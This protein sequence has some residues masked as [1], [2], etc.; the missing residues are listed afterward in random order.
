MPYQKPILVSMGDPAGCGPLLCDVLWNEV[1]KKSDKHRVAFV[2]C[3]SAFDAYSIPT[4]AYTLGDAIDMSGSLPLIQSH[5]TAAPVVPGEP[6][7]ANAASV[8]DAIAYAANACAAGHAAALIT[9]PI[10]KSILYD[11]GFSFAGH[12]EFLADICGLKPP[13]EKP[14]MMLTG[15]GLRVALATI[16]IPIRA[17]SDALGVDLLCTTA[18]IVNRDLKAKFSM[19]HPRI[20]FSGLNPHAGEGGSIG[21]E[22]IEIINP[23]AE[24][25]RTEGIDIS[26]ARPADT[27]FHEALT[28]QFDAVIAMTHDQGLIPVKTLDIW[29]GVNVTLGLPIIRTSPDHGTAFEAT[30]ARTLNPKSMLAAYD[31]ACGQIQSVMA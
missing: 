15:G 22:E 19:K 21:M 13:A 11:A 29:G 20:A 30:K 28:G 31:S 7:I 1:V 5:K 12:T 24:I 26:N 17:V 9:A 16:H 25:L 18:R 27:V 4:T 23:A 10:A 8:I 3:Q 6:D 2:G 14:I